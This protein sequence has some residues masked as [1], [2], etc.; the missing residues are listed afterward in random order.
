MPASAAAVRPA[1]TQR[2]TDR[3]AEVEHGP[4]EAGGRGAQVAVRVERGGVADGGEEGDVLVA[5]AVGVGLGEVDARARARRRVRRWPCAGPTA[6]GPSVAPVNWPSSTTSRVHTRCSTPRSRATGAI[7][8]F[9]AAEATAT[10]W[11]ARWC[12]STSARDSRRMVPAILDAEQPLAEVGEGLLGL[13]AHGGEGDVGDAGR[14]AAELAVDGGDDGAEEL[15]RRDVAALEPVAVE[16]G[17]GV[18]GDE[19][20]VEVEERADGRTL[21]SGLDRVDR[22]RGPL[23]RTRSPG[24]PASTTAAAGIGGGTT[25]TGSPAISPMMLTRRTASRSS[26]A[27]ASRAVPDALAA[28]EQALVAGERQGGAEQLERDRLGARDPSLQR[29]LPADGQRVGEQV[30]LVDRAVAAVGQP[31]GEDEVGVE[32]GPQHEVGEVRARVDE[33]LAR[34]RAASSR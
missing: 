3:V 25:C 17:G 10:V 12:A 9:V 7:W 31:V 1:A 21:G 13:P 33:Q 18:A 26:A 30:V 14:V 4:A 29:P 32:E 15:G 34:L 19:G 23:R 20:A 5:V 28:L 22:V 24:S 16:R 8:Y 6:S 11:P 27:N 2:A